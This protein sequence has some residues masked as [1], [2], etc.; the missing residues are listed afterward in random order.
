M[1]TDLVNAATL[2]VVLVVLCAVIKMY[3][4]VINIQPCR[5]DHLAH[6]SDMQSG[7]MMNAEQHC[8]GTVRM[9]GIER[10]TVQRVGTRPRPQENDE[11]YY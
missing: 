4:T 1:T 7:T 2:I 6:V 9:R 8:Y 3:L 11:R 10:Q 5:V